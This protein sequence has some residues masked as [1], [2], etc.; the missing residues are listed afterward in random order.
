MGG[1]S[2]ELELAGGC[3]EAEQLADA[4]FGLVAAFVGRQVYIAP[5]GDVLGQGRACGVRDNH[6]AYQVEAAVHYL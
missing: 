5:A 2:G 1:A 6:R 3:D 4:P